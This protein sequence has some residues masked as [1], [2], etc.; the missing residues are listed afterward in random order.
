[1]TV[2]ADRLRSLRFRVVAR[3]FVLLVLTGS[4][5][6]FGSLIAG[7]IVWQLASGRGIALALRGALALSLLLPLAFVV[8]GGELGSSA[9]NAISL[10]REDPGSGDPTSLTGRVPLWSVLIEHYVSDRPLLGHGF[11]GFWTPRH[12]VEVS[13][14]QD[15]AIEIGRASCRERVC[16]Y[17]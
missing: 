15:W 6:A 3:L 16:Q 4:L 8:A 10:G 2:R 1:M 12:I 9:Q 7:F 5:V 13:A 17:V 14:Y 11:Q